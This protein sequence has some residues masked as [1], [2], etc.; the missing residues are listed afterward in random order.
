MGGSDES[1]GEGGWRVFSGW[2]DEEKTP[3]YN[4]SR[5]LFSQLPWD[6]Q[7]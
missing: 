4:V 6:K 5:P 7:G 2:V 3:A 1:W